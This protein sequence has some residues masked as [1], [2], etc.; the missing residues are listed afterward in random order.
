MSTAAPTRVKRISSEAIHSL[1]NFAESLADTP[2]ELL[3]L[4]TAAMAVTAKRPERGIM[5]FKNSS[6]LT[7]KK[8][9]ASMMMSF[10]LFLMYLPPEKAVSKN[11]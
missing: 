6:A 8:A 10:T 1:P 9:K 11:V 3:S 4:M 2:F 5:P 7:G